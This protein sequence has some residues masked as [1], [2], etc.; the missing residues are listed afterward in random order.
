MQAQNRNR[1]RHKGTWRPGYKDKSGMNGRATAADIICAVIGCFCLHQ[2]GP[3]KE[4]IQNKLEIRTPWFF[5]G[6]RSLARDCTA[7][8]VFCLHCPTLFH[9]GEANMSIQRLFNA[10]AWQ[11]CSVP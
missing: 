3:V 11:Y 8:Q 2:M 1:R 4:W 5:L 9:R 10:L 6:G 7:P